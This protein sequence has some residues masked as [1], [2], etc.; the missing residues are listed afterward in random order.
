MSEIEIREYKSSDVPALKTLWKN[1]FGD[2]EGFLDAFFA[3]LPKIGSGLVAEYKGLICGAAYTITEQ[4]LSYPDGVKRRLAYI[5]GVCVAESFQGRGI[6][7]ELV[8]AVYSLSRQRGADIVCT[9]PAEDSLYSWYEKLID[10]NCAL[11][12]KV[13]AVNA[14]AGGRC[15]S[16][17]AG[18]YAVLREKLLAGKA[19]VCPNDDLMAFQGQMAREYGGGLYAVED[20]IA[21]A[22]KD[23]EVAVIRELLLPESGD[24]HAA[25]AALSY[26]MGVKGAM[27]FESAAQGKKYIAADCPLPTDCAWNLSLD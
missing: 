21:T 23:G 27:L 16:I 15:L 2:T 5:Y 4:Y 18:E 13:S 20:G 7:A 9:L 11:Y 17:S 19:H 25:A 6:G 8:K 10:V 1:I 14:M 12:R 22:Y 24:L 3:A 26:S